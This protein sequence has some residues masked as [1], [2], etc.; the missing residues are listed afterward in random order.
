MCLQLQYRQVGI[1]TEIWEF[2]INFFS[3]MYT[4]GTFLNTGFQPNTSV[5]SN[6]AL[7]CPHHK[8]IK[9]LVANQWEYGCIEILRVYDE[10]TDVGLKLLV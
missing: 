8:Y 7:I 1:K 10:Y 3:C 5:S 6:R 2:E 4:E 9:Y